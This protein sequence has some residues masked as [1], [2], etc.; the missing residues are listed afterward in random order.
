MMNHYQTLEDNKENFI[1][2]HIDK[3]NIDTIE[4][5]DIYDHSL[6]RIKN[7][8]TISTQTIPPKKISEIIKNICYQLL[9]IFITFLIIGPF[10]SVISFNIYYLHKYIN[11][12]KA[13]PDTSI[14]LIIIILSVNLIYCSYILLKQII[15]HI[16]KIC[17][18]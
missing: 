18:T 2:I 6:N 17:N 1:S 8:R 16:K 15:Y 9:E 3:E 5:N 10:I 11:D 7:M 4:N 14:I 13:I 12:N